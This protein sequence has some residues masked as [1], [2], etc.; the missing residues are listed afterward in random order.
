MASIRDYYQHIDGSR[1]PQSASSEDNFGW[2]DS[3]GTNTNHLCHTSAGEIVWMVRRDI[4]D[5]DNDGYAAYEICD[6]NDATLNL[7]DLLTMGLQPV[8]VIAMIPMR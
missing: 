7:D 8:M 4:S 5:S 6:D 1:V 2:A 3:G